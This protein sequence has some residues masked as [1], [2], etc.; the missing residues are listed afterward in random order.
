MTTYNRKTL[1][2]N[3]ALT[4]LIS[5]DG[6]KS[7]TPV[8]FYKSSILLQWIILDGAKSP[9]D[10]SGSIFEF[11]MAE[12]YNTTPIAIVPNGDFVLADWSESD[13]T[14]GQVCC[15][16][17]MDQAAILAVIDESNYK[18]VHCALWITLDGI[19]YCLASFS[20]NIKN[21]VS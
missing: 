9:V 15:R 3:S 21:L 12:N 8:F 14:K 4:S 10:L 1:Y 16:L 5:Q 18:S 11:R 13:I 2:V 7:D 17:D 20:A 6:S 19:D